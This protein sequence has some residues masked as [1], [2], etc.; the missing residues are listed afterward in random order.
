MIG[1]LKGKFTELDGNIGL[2]ETSSGVFYKVFLTPKIYQNKK[3]GSFIEI[4]T[5]L[6]V[7]ENNLSLF[8][9]EN[10]KQYKLFQ[11]LLSVD[12]IGPKSAFSIIS[13]EQEDKILTAVS[14]NNVI[15]FSSI[16][17]IGKKTAQK[18]ILELS[19][20]I[21]KNFE[22]QSLHLSKEDTTA[23]EALTSLGFKKYDSQNTL[24]KIDKKLSL[25]EKI[26]S[27]IKIMT[28]NE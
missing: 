16:P 10:K 22:L 27:A 3:P 21:G 8:G 6:Q 26:K 11:M 5:Y 24:S 19:S 13:F 7:R 12:G 17:G 2:I 18:I 25:E 28:K 9:F 4:Y 1:K 23:I 15:F 14:N 20:K